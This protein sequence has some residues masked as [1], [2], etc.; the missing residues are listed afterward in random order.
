MWFS[1]VVLERNEIAAIQW[2]WQVGQYIFFS[3]T[4]HLLLNVDL[5][6]QTQTESGMFTWLHDNYTNAVQPRNVN[7]PITQAWASY[8]KSPTCK[9]IIAFDVLLARLKR[10]GVNRQLCLCRQASCSVP[11]LCAC[12]ACTAV[13]PS[14][15]S[16][17]AP[18]PSTSPCSLRTFSAFSVES[19]SSSIV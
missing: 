8:S 6:L 2:S 10:A 5:S 4:L 15:W 12:S 11:T 13:C 14:W 17:A 16:W 7:E 3:T 1:R 18:P 19:S 9:S